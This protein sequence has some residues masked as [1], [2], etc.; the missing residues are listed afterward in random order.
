ME[1]EQKSNN[2][3][4]KIREK[5]ET[6]KQYEIIV[7]HEHNGVYFCTTNYI[8]FYPYNEFGE[9]DSHLG[10]VKYKLIGEI[11]SKN[12]VINYPKT[13]IIQNHSH[14]SSDSSYHLVDSICNL[15]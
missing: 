6:E 5:Y 11:Q 2:P 9:T 12:T 7:C 13:T 8:D 14:S 3:I 4:I 1:T 15:F 10:N